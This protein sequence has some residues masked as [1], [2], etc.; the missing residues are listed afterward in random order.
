MGIG[1]VGGGRRAGE[2]KTAT[3]VLPL[4]AA[5]SSSATQRNVAHESKAADGGVQRELGHSR[6]GTH[7]MF[8]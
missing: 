1:W 2:D 7:R 5:G 3:E 8:S 4:G 6:V